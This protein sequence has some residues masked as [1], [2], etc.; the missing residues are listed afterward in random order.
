K[1]HV[2]GV[3]AEG[4]RVSMF[5][6]RITPR[7]T[8]S[9]SLRAGQDLRC[10]LDLYGNECLAGTLGVLWH[11]HVHSAFEFSNWYVFCGLRFALRGIDFSRA[12]P[13]PQ[14][15]RKKVVRGTER[16]H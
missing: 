4:H 16:F 1:E 14:I 11:S 12:R 15:C 13:V 10:E 8:I 6:E 3:P 7:V 2:Y 5:S 9:E